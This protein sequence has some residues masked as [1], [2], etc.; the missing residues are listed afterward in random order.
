MPIY[1]GQ[2][3]CPPG[4]QKSDNPY[5]TTSI[6]AKYLDGEDG[7]FVELPM[8]VKY[9]LEASGTFN[10]TSASGYLSDAGYTWVNGALSNQY[11]I[12][13]TGSDY[14]AHA[15]LSDFGTGKVGVVDWGVV[16]S[17]GHIYIKYYEPIA[18]DTTQFVIGDRYGDWFG[19]KW[20]NQE[21]MKDNLE[22][23][24][25][26]VYT[27][28]DIPQQ[29]DPVC[30][31]GIKEGSEECDGEDGVTGGENF[32]TDTC[33]L[34]PVYNGDHICSKGTQMSETP[35]K[36]ISVSSQNSDGEEVNLA[37]GTYL[38]KVSGQYQFD[39]SDI[40]KADAGYGTEDN[41][42]SLRQDLGILEGAEHR[43]VLSLLSDM[44]TEIIPDLTM[45][46]S[47]A[48]DVIPE[49]RNKM[50]CAEDLLGAYHSILESF[51]SPNKYNR[52]NVFYL[53]KIA[54][55][56]ARRDLPDFFIYS[57][58][59]MPIKQAMSLLNFNGILLNGK[60]FSKYI[61]GNNLNKVA[62][63]DVK[64]LYAIVKFSQ[65]DRLNSLLTSD[66]FN[67]E[68]NGIS[69]SNILNNVLEKY[70][71]FPQYVQARIF[72]KIASIGSLDVPL[73]I[74]VA[75]PIT[76]LDCLYA[77]YKISALN[78]ILKHAKAE[79]KKDILLYAVLQELI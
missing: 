69:N 13:G 47:L 59:K 55:D 4:T 5:L 30:N 41:W 49:L 34:I 48:G 64:S 31:N 57:L 35:I 40:R 20:D 42:A 10:P 43:G 63:Q 15:L 9:L 29:S 74:N 58:R 66:R 37:A 72:E 26:N 21:G 56:V 71:C 68:S 22:S 67:V 12:H 6:S 19:T 1:D 32:C 11:G 44:G 8:G 2:H 24:T 62:N 14:A 73:N 76:K 28:D 7:E 45:P 3:S 33:K 46:D 51:I 50:K 60:E 38:F 65:Q 16:N 18:S 70:S 52:A 61:L 39:S 53:R 23:L 27:C 78:N 79:E 54:L 36:S 17:D 77:N 75:K 25:L